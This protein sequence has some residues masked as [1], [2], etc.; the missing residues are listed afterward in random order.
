M[1]VAIAPDDVVALR[2]LTDAPVR[3][4]E[5][6]AL[7]HAA[8]FGC[9]GVEQHW[10][11]GWLLRAGRGA[12]F[13]ANSAVPLDVSANVATIPSIAEWY[14]RRGLIPRLR[15]PDRLLRLSGAGGRA[16][17][18]LVRDA[19][20]TDPDPSV[21]LVQRPDDDW[22][23]LYDRQVP[24]DVLTAILDG[25]LAFGR[26]AGEAVGRAAVTDAPDGT[27]WVG[28]S[29]LRIV[30]ERHAAGAALCEALLSWGAGRGATRGYVRLLDEA[31][32]VGGVIES[33]GF[34]LHHRSLDV[35]V[36]PGFVR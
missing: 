36:E 30:A 14:G 12:T 29:A 17:R 23:R 1:V 15:V 10:L 7:E 16:R 34:T 2:A 13:T 8:A 19:R 22:L 24:V 5:I 9:P 27:R 32:P 21:S 4:S 33:L 31:T 20:A 6:R 11:E 35:T 25:E 28:L 26:Y 18:M 3:T